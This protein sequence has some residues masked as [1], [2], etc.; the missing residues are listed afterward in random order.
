V[1][2][3]QN[4]KFNRKWKYLDN[5]QKYNYFEDLVDLIR[6]V[7]KEGLKSIL[8]AS[9]PNES[10][11]KNF[12]DHVNK[13]HRWLVHSKGYNRV[14]FGEIIGNANSLEAARFLI[15]QNKSLDILSETTTN[16]LNQIVDK[17][18]KLIKTGDPNKL[19]LYD[20]KEIENLI[21]GKNKR[22]LSGADLLDFLVTTESKLNN[23]KKRNRI[24]RL[25]QI[26][27]N[28]G[29]KTKTISEEN[30]AVENFNQLGGI[31]AFKK[32]LK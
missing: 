21:Y 29:V 26:A 2:V 5:K 23:P 18:N 8:L 28:K 17:L 7:I 11:S 25:I 31:V 24:H 6:V 13:H 15:S 3:Y 16:E 22:D 4:I 1:R 30:P 9:P 14:S 27:T 20:L 32:A 10:N 19:L 12:L